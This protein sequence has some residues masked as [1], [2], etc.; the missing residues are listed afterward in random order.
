MKSVE[1]MTELAEVRRSVAW[2]PK[3][4]ARAGDNGQRSGGDW[5][6]GSL[7]SYLAHPF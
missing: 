2:R 1:V 3:L 5:N 7:S 4:L 6:V